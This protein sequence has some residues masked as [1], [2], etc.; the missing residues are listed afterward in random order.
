MPRRAREI[1]PLGAGP[2]RDPARLPLTSRQSLPRLLE[3]PAAAAS[4]RARRRV[5]RRLLADL[6][7]GDDKA[8]LREFERHFG[9]PVRTLEKTNASRR[10]TFGPEAA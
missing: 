7:A 2:P 6:I 5:E 4:P 3:A 9:D 8:A 1:A 10:E